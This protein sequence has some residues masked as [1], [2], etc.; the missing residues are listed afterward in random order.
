MRTVALVAIAACGVPSAVL[1]QGPQASGRLGD[2]PVRLEVPLLAAPSEVRPEGIRFVFERPAPATPGP[3][4]QT[5]AGGR[6]GA[7]AG[8]LLGMAIGPAL[9]AGRDMGCDD[10]ECYGTLSPTE[11]SVAGAVVAGGVG[12]VLGNV[13]ALVTDLGNPLLNSLRINFSPKGKPGLKVKT[14]IRF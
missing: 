9:L 4:S 5:A 1:A 13:L 3:L 6:A 14:S 8:W 12:Y 2:F 10:I 7:V 11:A